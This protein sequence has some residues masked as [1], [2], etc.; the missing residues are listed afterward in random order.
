MRPNMIKGWMAVNGMT[1]ASIA[2][3]AGVAYSTVHRF[4]EGEKTSLPLFYWYVRRGCPRE[5]FGLK[6]KRRIQR[7]AA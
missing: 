2:R 1:R 4:V 7:E 5:Y 6:Y 3:D